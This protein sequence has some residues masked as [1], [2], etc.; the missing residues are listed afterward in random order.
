MDFLDNHGWELQLLFSFS[1]RTLSVL[2]WRLLRCPLAPRKNWQ[3]GMGFFLFL[4][5]W[6]SI[7]KIL[8]IHETQQRRRQREEQASCRDPDVGLDPRTPG[9]HPGPKADALPL[10]HPGVPRV[11]NSFRARL[12]GPRAIPAHL[13]KEVRAGPAGLPPLR[14]LGDQVRPA[15]VEAGSGLA[16]RS[17]AF[18]QV[19]CR[20]P[21]L[22]ASP[23]AGL[24][25]PGRG[26]PPPPPPPPG[27]SV[28][29]RG[30]WLRGACWVFSAYSRC[31]ISMARVRLRPPS[32][33]PSLCPLLAGSGG[34]GPARVL[35]TALSSR[36]GVQGQVEIQADTLGMLTFPRKAWDSEAQNNNLSFISAPKVPL[37]F[38]PCGAGRACLL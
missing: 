19:G 13:G 37:G 26:P 1:F 18:L 22:R 38:A 16:D 31:L 6:S 3:G 20:A 2:L 4:F 11:S 12:P 9:S 23:S 10:S 14:C 5:N 33:A 8:F 34:G 24:R 29:W 7:C 17:G 27:S 32:G 36:L 28:G 21:G 25:G 35:V 15:A 30:W